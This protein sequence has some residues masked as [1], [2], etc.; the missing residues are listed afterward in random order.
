MLSPTISHL[1]S[2]LF[3]SNLGSNSLTYFSTYFTQ[4][5]FSRII[6]FKFNPNPIFKLL[7]IQVDVIRVNAFHASPCF[8]GFYCQRAKRGEIDAKAQTTIGSVVYLA[9]GGRQPVNEEAVDPPNLSSSTLSELY[10]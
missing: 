5:P 7:L 8:F 3:P 10:C 2:G 6:W 4:L 1:I 9:C